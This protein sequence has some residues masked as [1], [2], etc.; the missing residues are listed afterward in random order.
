MAILIFM[1]SLKWGGLP[2]GLL[3]LFLGTY[4][5]STMISVLL[6]VP[7]SGLAVLGILLLYQFFRGNRAWINP[8]LNLQSWVAVQ[9]GSHNSNTDMI[10]WNDAFYMIHATSPF[11]LASS[12]CHLVI[13]RSEDGSGWEEISRLDGAGQD[14]R[15]P[16]FA[17]IKGR[18]FVYALLN[19]AMNPEPYK[20]V[21]ACS[22][23]A[24]NWT[25]FKSLEHEGW[26]FWRPKT[27][28]GK[29]WYLPAYWWEHGKS[30]L[31][32]SEDGINWE[33]VSEIHNG[34]RND[35]TAIEFMEDGSLIATARLEYSE[36][37]TGDIRGCTQVSVAS[38]P[39]TAWQASTKC[40]LTRLDGPCLFS[41]KEKIYAVG[42]YQP[43]TTGLI[44][45]QGSCFTSKR[46]SLFRVREKGLE[47]LTDFPSAGDT[48][49]AGVVVRGNE[50][51]VCYYT[52]DIDR[53]FIW[54]DGMLEP[55]DI[56]IA[57]LNLD[58]LD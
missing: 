38:P 17:V 19:I 33:Y 14:I 5:P 45:R 51:T 50:L 56:M 13:R 24:I 58:L 47:R 54:L 37:L 43:R 55:S 6:Y 28:D 27:R 48:A 12:S 44:S 35:E 11:H 9:D 22:E 29:T 15:D 2:A 57:R 4:S 34:G 10:Y 36:M 49:Y 18:L 31:F 25:S 16:K 1:R 30:A 39:Y 53:D 21:Y 40:Y 3:L 23:D 41:Y 52:N 46:T 7:G 20:T 26:L 8:D 32:R 42:R